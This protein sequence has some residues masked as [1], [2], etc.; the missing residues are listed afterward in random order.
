VNRLEL[1]EILKKKGIV[2][3]AYSIFGGLPGD[4]YV[5]SDDGYGVWSIY[6]S[7]R[8]ERLGEKKFNSESEACSYFLEKLLSDPTV[9]EKK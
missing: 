8:G 3:S 6:Y 1:V 9:F 4:K 2:E 5:F 7:E